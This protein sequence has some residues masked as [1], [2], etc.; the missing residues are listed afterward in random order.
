MP[1]AVRNFDGV[2]EVLVAAA[3]GRFPNANLSRF[4]DFNKRL[5]VVALGLADASY[6][7]RQAQLDVMPD[8]AEGEFLV[9]HGNV[10]G[11]AQKGA[12]GSAG[13]SVLRV[14]GV[15]ASV[16]PVFEPLTHTPSQLLFETRSGGVIPAAG[17]L[18]VDIAALSTGIGTN[19]EQDQELTFDTPPAGIDAAARVLFDLEGGLDIES[20]PDYQARILDRIGEPE[21]GGSRADFEKWVLEAADFVATAYVYPTRN[22]LGTV[23]L[24]GLKTGRG[25]ARLLS[26]GERTTIFNAVELLRPVGATIRVLEVLAEL[27]DVEFTIIPE[28]GTAFVFDWDDVTPPVILTYVDGTRVL[29]FDAARPASMQVGD[30]LTL[31]DPLSDGSESV[32]EQ[33]DGTDA[34][35]LVEA[36]GFAPTPTNV[37]YSGG[38]LVEPVRLN[39]LALFDAL[40]PANPDASAYGPWEGNLRVSNLFEAVQTTPGVLDSVVLDPL[41]TVEAAD[42]AFPANTTVGLLIP[43]KILVRRFH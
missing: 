18:D 32:I 7:L 11:V 6:N 14:T 22:G 38:P 34:V 23:D 13:D 30:R 41:V 33:L 29:T 36:L 3:G 10:W 28:T 15:A 26:L 9:R 12:V 24:V 17:F 2:L 4:S 27:T 21:L 5:R 25:T 16:V 20:D 31:D 40:G 19:L 39:I 43:Q 42:P 35:I 8:T 37:V 1:F